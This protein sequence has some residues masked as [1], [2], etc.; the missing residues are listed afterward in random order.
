MIQMVGTTL[1]VGELRLAG[2]LR[3]LLREACKLLQAYKFC[4]AEVLV[5]SRLFMIMRLCIG[6]AHQT[7]GLVGAAVLQGCSKDIAFNMCLLTQY[8]LEGFLRSRG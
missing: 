5:T 8:R 7:G 6:S 1:L 3:K 2:R 4:A